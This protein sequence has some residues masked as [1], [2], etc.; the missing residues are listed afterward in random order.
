[1]KSAFN[2]HINERRDDDCYC[3]QDI[4]NKTVYDLQ[5]PFFE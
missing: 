1:M 4:H 2:I 5:P 3:M